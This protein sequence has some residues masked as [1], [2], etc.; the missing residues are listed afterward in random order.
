MHF[1]I[2]T[3][4]KFTVVTPISG[5]LSAN[6]AAE[7]AQTGSGIL[8][9]DVKNVILQM[10][11]VSAVDDGAAAVLLE[12]SQQFYE[13]NASFVI[14]CL[15]PAVEEQ[16]EQKELLEMLNVTPTES[17]AWDIVQ[18]E[19]IERELLDGDDMEFESNA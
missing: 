7:L 9:K 6:I 16:L 4:E 5:V 12:M 2:D 17:E 11:Q 13:S 14:C 8:E 1:K 15:Q 3:K 10:E 19:E 18:M